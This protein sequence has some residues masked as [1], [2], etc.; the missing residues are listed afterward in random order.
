ME[1]FSWTCPY[2][3]RPTTITEQ[4][5]S[6]NYHNIYLPTKPKGL[7]IRT[8]LILCP[9]TD[10]N[11]F[12]VISELGTVTHL[13]TGRDVLGNVL[14]HWNLKPNSNAKPLPDYIPEPVRKDY[15]ESCQIVELSPKAS[16]TISRR[17]LQG[18]IRDYWNISKDR[19]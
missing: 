3:N 2:C 17:C 11:E 9:N 1:N 13:S 16:A 15:E 6:E 19:I 5:Q 10:C 12:T 4:D 14:S 8:Q 7:G 18:M